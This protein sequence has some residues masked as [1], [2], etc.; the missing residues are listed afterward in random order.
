MVARNS[1]VWNINQSNQSSGIAYPMW[2]L[3]IKGHNDWIQGNSDRCDKYMDPSP[4]AL[5]D[6]TANATRGLRSTLLIGLQA[7]G[8]KA[9]AINKRLVARIPADL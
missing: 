1:A 3:S 7:S 9:S 8:L 5:T 6:K 2:Q 4:V